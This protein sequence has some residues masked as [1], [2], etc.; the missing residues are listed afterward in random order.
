M[1]IRNALAAATIGLAG[2]SMTGI[3]AAQAADLTLERVML[4]TGGVGY[5]EWEAKVEGNA[6]LTLDVPLDQV[7]DVLKSLVVFDDKGG[8][9]G[10]ELPGLEPVSQLFR[11]LPFGP[12]ALESPVALLNA[13]Q[14]S[15]IIATGSRTL[16]G[17]LLKVE[18]ETV[19]LPG[20]GGVTTRHRI[21]LAT[22][23]G[24]QQL[25]LEDAQSVKFADPALQ[26]QVDKALAALSVAH[27]RDRRSLTIT[28]NGQ[29]TRT[30]R[31]AYVVAAPLWKTS[32][33]LTLPS[34][35]ESTQSRLQGW[36]VIENMS[37]QDWK[38]VELTL[39]S[40]S[41]VTF[42]QALYA[43]YYVDRQEVPVEV[44]GRILPN[45]D[46]GS[47]AYA[48]SA[49]GSSD[50]DDGER[51][52]RD[53]GR[54]LTEG[55]LGGGAAMPAP[56]PIMAAPEIAPPPPPYA[57]Q[58]AGGSTEVAST[59]ALTQ[60][61]FKLGQ[62]VSV[63]S[64]RSLSVPIIDRDVPAE[65]LALYQPGVHQRH[66]LA[67]VRLKN[68]GQTGLP[69][70]IL[71]IYERTAADGSVSYGY[72]GDARL[73]A[74]PAGEERMVSYAL[75]Q[76]VRIDR[77][78]TSD[79]TLTTGTIERGVFRTTSMEQRVI[80]YKIAGPAREARKLILEIPKL[81]GYDLVQPKEGIEENDQYWR[82]PAKVAA[83][84]TVEVKVIA[85]RPLV[86]TVSIGDM[87]DGQ[88]AYY[89]ANNALDAKTRAAFAK[90]AELK[91][92]LED[93][94]SLSESLTAKLE[95]LTEEQSRLRANLDAVPRDSDL[96]RRYLKKLDDQ[97]TAIEGLQTR[98]A[99][100]DEAAEAAEKKLGDYLATL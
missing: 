94:Q 11:D 84:K 85:Q 7:D 26:A 66:P 35:L 76:K 91:R 53:Y 58:M 61:V 72:V 31:V 32:Y 96:Y 40:G 48:A 29:G 89:A 1:A 54:A 21:T 60:V 63:T 81:S 33:R 30:V 46:T 98:I 22:E 97:E 9:G 86:T 20:E 69:P 16:T 88:I 41:P 10:M 73:A 95:A 8:V 12:E 62:P 47:S 71:T 36:A 42:R 49:P 74:L 25:I 56:A 14:G 99:D 90:I 18:P 79:S 59:E 39:V 2:L 34:D 38:D 13:L 3:S 55:A 51:A 87:G 67:A 6:T 100:A 50:A 15:E 70:G 28:S 82:I 80:T 43:S 64:G 75:D 27:A 4:S 24:L 45:V 92:S 65:R 19:Q 77:A 5:F 57:P 44:V 17:R 68:D 93:Q 52:R 37:G 23:A 83:G 78:E